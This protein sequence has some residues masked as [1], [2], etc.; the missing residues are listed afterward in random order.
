MSERHPHNYLRKD[1]A[2]ADL[3]SP[4]RCRH[5][6]QSTLLAFLLY[7]RK[8]GEKA[9]RIAERVATQIKTLEVKDAQLKAAT[10]A[11]RTAGGAAER[12]RD[13]TF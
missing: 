5:R 8:S 12:M 7:L 6:R 1:Q 13:G 3:R 4:L 9:G 2:L 11:P 10:A